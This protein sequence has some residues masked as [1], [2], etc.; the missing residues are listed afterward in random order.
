MTSAE[1]LEI[2]WVSHS[3]AAI[4]LMMVGNF[5]NSTFT[6]FRKPGTNDNTPLTKLLMHVGDY[7][8]I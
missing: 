7:D 1:E 2:C 6:M 5:F 8:F 4:P 3:C